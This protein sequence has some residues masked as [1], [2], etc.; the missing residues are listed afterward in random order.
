VDYNCTGILED[1]V[2][3]GTDKYRRKIIEVFFQISKHPESASFWIATPSHENNGK[4]SA[5]SMGSVA[6]VEPEDADLL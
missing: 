1:D 5:D 3:G 4:A 2:V 6:V